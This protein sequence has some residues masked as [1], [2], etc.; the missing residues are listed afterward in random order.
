MTKYIALLSGKGGTGKT[1][2]SINLAHALTK[3]GKKVIILDANFATPNLASHLGITS[4]STTLN[5]FLKKKKALQETIH[6]HHSGLKFIPASI[7]YQDFKK[8]QPDK[9][10]EV[11]EHL[12]NLADFVLVDC[13]AGLGYE[14]VQ[15]LKNTDEAIIIMN[16]NLSSLIDALKSIEITQENNNSLPGF[17]LN[18]SFKGRNELKPEEIE[19]TLNI[20]LIANVPYDKKI[21]KSLYKQAPSH[22]L[23]PRSKSSK[24]YLKLAEQLIY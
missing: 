7:S 14:L 12:K 24:Q 11:F 8:A 10:T 13:P 1:T 2:T 9:I 17:V 22:Y 4:P 6:L 3:L 20:P 16:P 18:M 19:K 23:Y 5:D 21:K 15:I